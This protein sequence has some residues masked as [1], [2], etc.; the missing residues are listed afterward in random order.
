[1]NS[2]SLGVADLRKATGW[3]RHRARMIVLRPYSLSYKK[4][5]S[6]SKGGGRRAGIGSQTFWH[7]AGKRQAPLIKWKTTSLPLTRPTGRNT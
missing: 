2:F 4:D 1:M 3:G 5:P 6:G 7:V